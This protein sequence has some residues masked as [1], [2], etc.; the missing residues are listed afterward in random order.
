MLN[1]ARKYLGPGTMLVL[2]IT[3]ALFIL[4]LFVKGVTHDL[5]DLLLEAAVFLVSVKLIVMTY[6]NSKGVEAI[7]AKL[8]KIL[9]EEEH[10]EKVLNELKNRPP[11]D[12]QP[13]GE[14][15]PRE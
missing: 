7:Q 10:L 5:F 8:D 2:V 15:E 6:R 3:L 11:E 1:T 9:T 4:A 13:G 14:N 12:R